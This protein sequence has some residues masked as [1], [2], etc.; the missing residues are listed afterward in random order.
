MKRLSLLLLTLVVTG[1]V[2]AKPDA[3]T[4]MPQ[5]QTTMKQKRQMRKNKNVESK[6]SRE[7]EAY[8]TETYTHGGARGGCKS[9]SCAPRVRHEHSCRQEGS[10]GVC[11][12]AA[13][14]PKPDCVKAVEVK[15]EPCLHKQTYFSWTCPVGTTLQER[16]GGNDC[17]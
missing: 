13:I 14:P 4:A 3:D 12:K 15:E 6:N 9:G 1:A 2:V 17:Y 11:H 7:S 10:C 16:S 8:M 5:E